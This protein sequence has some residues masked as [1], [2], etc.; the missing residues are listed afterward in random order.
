MRCLDNKAITDW[1]D[2]RSLSEDPYHRGSS[3]EF[4]LQFYTP[5]DH[6]T[7]DAFVRHYYDRIISDLDS[8]IHM[9]DW[10]LYQKSDMITV[11]GIRSSSGEDR[12]LIDAPGH[13]LPHAEMEIGVTL[14]GLSTS[15]GWSSYLYSQRHRSTLF[16]W[17]GDILDFWTDSEDRFSEM[18]LMIKQFELAETSNGEQVGTSNPLHLQ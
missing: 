6:S 18:R 3:H 1:L 16:N 7:F 17:E 2:S 4:Y 9:T 11:S 12:M 15:F 8:L 5:N 13:V 14:F 10:S